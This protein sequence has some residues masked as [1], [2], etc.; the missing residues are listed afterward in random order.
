MLS[1]NREP[2]TSFKDSFK[3]TTE[4]R[5]S[6]VRLEIKDRRTAVFTA[7][8][9]GPRNATAWVRAWV[10]SEAEG[11]IAQAE[12]ADISV[13]AEVSLTVVM[14]REATPELA[15]MRIESEEF[16]TKHT[17]HVELT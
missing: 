8:A 9:H 1:P 4:Y 11:T 16:A 14:N 15:C 5:L 7:F 6:D 13:G 10:S 12:I 17:V 3:P 2:I